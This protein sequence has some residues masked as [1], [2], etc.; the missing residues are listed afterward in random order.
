MAK[1]YSKKRSRLLY[2]V[3]LGC[4]TVLLIA[5]AVYGLRL[6]W[7]Y[8]EEYEDARP[9]HAIDAYVDQL[10]T[11]LW[12]DGVAR[13]VS[14]MVSETQSEEQV[15]ALV[16]EHLRSGVSA[17]RKGSTGGEEHTVTYSLRCEGEEI[18]SVSIMEDSAYLN[19]VQ[20]G[21]L[22]WKVSDDSFNFDRFY[23]GVEVVVPA[24]YSVWI[25]GVQLGEDCIVERDIPYDVFADYYRYW[26][27]LPTKVKY[28]YDRV[29]GEAELVIRNE[30]G[31]VV[32]IDESRGDE[33]FLTPFPQDQIQRYYNFCDPFTRQYL[34]YTAGLSNRAESNYAALVPYLLP[35]SDLA[36]R[37][38]DALDG[39]SWGH[40]AS[41]EIQDIRIN[42]ILPLVDGYAVCDVSADVKTFTYGKGEETRTTNFR[43]ITYDDGAKILGESIELY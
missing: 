11:E 16:Q 31:D 12:N 17:V 8:A 24:E 35:E 4:W 41:I 6:A 13:A 37:M 36:G 20:F 7:Q 18:G 10:N 30:H 9:N 43:L 27:T 25:N 28:S 2:I 33:Q 29:L 19:Y 15:K 5:A 14:S 23:S 32:T 26:D 42:S 21:M 34:T 22:P 40:T 39:L 3:A 1:A 38:F